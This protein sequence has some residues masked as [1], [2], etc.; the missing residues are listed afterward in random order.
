MSVVGTVIGIS[1]KLEWQH[2]VLLSSAK[3]N[4]DLLFSSC[5]YKRNR[6]WCDCLNVWND[7][8]LQNDHNQML[9]LLADTF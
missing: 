3:R 1:L 8:I 5:M 6:N 4:S 2:Q 9:L 7:L